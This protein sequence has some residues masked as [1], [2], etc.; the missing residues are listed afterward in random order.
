MPM[1]R[2]S[3]RG[4]AVVIDRHRNIALL[5][6]GTATVQVVDGRQVNTVTESSLS[7]AIASPGPQGP[8]GEAGNTILTYVAGEAV[9]GHRVVRSIGGGT[10]GYASSNDPTGGDDT[11]GLTLAAAAAGNQ[12]DV[13]NSGP[14]T[15]AGWTWTPGA[16]VFVGL[17][18]LLTQ[19]PPV[20]GYVQSMGH[21]EGPTTIFLAIGEATFLD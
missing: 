14:V 3:G 19:T 12:V 13:Q 4:V 9:G 1:I 17:S 18:G 16:P 15:F 21:A 10:C 5:R 2:A 11:I 7:V 20:T 8:K 6:P